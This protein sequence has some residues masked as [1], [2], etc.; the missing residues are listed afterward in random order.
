MR[1]FTRRTRGSV[2]MPWQRDKDFI[3]LQTVPPGD[4]I[5]HGLPFE[6]TGKMARRRERLAETTLPQD[7][8]P[9]FNKLP[10]EVRTQ[11]YSHMWRTGGYSGGVHIE[12][13]DAWGSSHSVWSYPCVVDAHCSA[14]RNEKLDQLWERHQQ[15]VESGARRKS[16]IMM[17][18]K[19]FPK[20]HA[21]QHWEC[22]EPKRIE[23]LTGRRLKR[24]APFLPVLLTCKRL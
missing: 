5:S 4:I 24:W 21:V 14:E 13:G 17:L 15:D 20:L 16:D 11:I 18:D 7:Q 19:S 23:E 1:N 12:L 8:S 9:F 2:R 6:D 10:G 3:I 22:Y